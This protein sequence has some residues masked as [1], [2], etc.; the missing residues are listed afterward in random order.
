MFGMKELKQEK[1]KVK[2]GERTKK[3]KRKETERD[4]IIIVF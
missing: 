3:R 2:E 1:G 4:S